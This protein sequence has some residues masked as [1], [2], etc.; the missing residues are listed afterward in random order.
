MKLYDEQ[1]SVRE[2]DPLESCAPHAVYPFRLMNVGD[3]F[4]LPVPGDNYDRRRELSMKLY[5][6]G[7]HFGRRNPPFKIVTSYDRKGTIKVTR[8]R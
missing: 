7:S 6:A 1:G 5:S 3:Y 2:V 8:I 4:F